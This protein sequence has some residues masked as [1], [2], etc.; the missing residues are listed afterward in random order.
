[1]LYERFLIENWI[2]YTKRKENFV[3]LLSLLSRIGIKQK[4]E[5]MMGVPVDVIRKTEYMRPRFKAR[6][7]KEV[8]Y[9]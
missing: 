5:K 9:V 1:L 7:E 3:F 6:I 8:I 4:L 2:Y